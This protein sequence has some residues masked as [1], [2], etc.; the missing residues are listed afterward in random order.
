M[1]LDR[2]IPRSV[3]ISRAT[4]AN[5]NARILP[6]LVAGA[7]LPSCPCWPAV[8]SWHRGILED[9]PH[10]PG[11]SLSTFK[12]GL[13][14]YALCHLKLPHSKLADSHLALLLTRPC[15]PPPPSMQAASPKPSASVVLVYGTANT[16]STN[17]SMNRK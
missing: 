5:A 9:D 4:L 10:M 12:L 6:I 13:R 1:H 17:N 3:H 8:V 11:P 2:R 15:R 7:G 14:F 16:H